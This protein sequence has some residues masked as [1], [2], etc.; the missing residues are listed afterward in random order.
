M[1]SGPGDDGATFQALFELAGVGMAQADAATGRYLRVNR[2]LC[3]ITGYSREELLTLTFA[4]IT[5][6]DDRARDL[7]T[8]GKLLRGEIPEET[9]E[10][11]YICKG[12]EVV[13]VQVSARL[14]RDPGGRPLTTVAVMQD[15]TARRRAESAL[16]ESEGRFRLALRSRAVVVFQQDMELRYVWVY[17]QDPAF[18]QHNIGRTDAELLP[19]DEAEALT[20]L[21]RRVLETGKSRHELIHASLPGGQRRAYDL[22]VE[23]WYD[24]AGRLAGVGGTALDVTE[25]AA[26]AE[27]LEEAARR[28]DE[29]LATLAHELRNP[30]APVRNSIEVLRLIGAGGPEAAQARAVIERQVRH[31]TRLIDDLLDVS[32]ITRGKAL[33]RAEPLDLVP[34]VRAA[35]EDHRAMLRGTGLELHLDLP[36]APLRVRGDPTRLAQVVGNLLHNANKFTDAGGEVRLSLER[37]TAGGEAVLTVRDTGIGMG[38]D[39]LAQLFEPFSQ[40]ERSLDRTRGGLGL[41][42]ALVKGLTELHGGRVSATSPGQGRGS[43]FT[44]RLPLQGTAS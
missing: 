7:E 19:P 24:E 11:R 26:A 37:D 20:R 3:E 10:K 27:A 38:P 5:H 42:L 33:L 31:M 44:V 39:T 17:P 28:K 29:F 12:G 21:K 41:G 18:D 4:D 36:D 43:E 25:R 2:K 30:L 1:R 35:A 40:A 6:P 32:R 9:I 34:L 14:V 13:W 23:P 8:F 16:R 15:V 22:F